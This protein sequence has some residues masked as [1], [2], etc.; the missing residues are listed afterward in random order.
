MKVTGQWTIREGRQI[1]TATVG[2]M[3]FQK[4]ITIRVGWTQCRVR[5]R[6]PKM[7]GAT[8]ATGSDTR[9]A[10]APVVLFGAPKNSSPR[11]QPLDTAH[12]LLDTYL[13][14]HT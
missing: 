4:L 13:P 6:K 9:R 14:K 8:N 12:Y 5:V 7:P 1:A 2:V 10:S 11:Y 3:D